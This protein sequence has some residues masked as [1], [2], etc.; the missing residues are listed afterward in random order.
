MPPRFQRMRMQARLR[1]P[2]IA[3]TVRVGEIARPRRMRPNR[4]F[5]DP[6]WTTA[7]C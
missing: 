7:A 6:T 5:L 2:V 4:R 3:S 1:S